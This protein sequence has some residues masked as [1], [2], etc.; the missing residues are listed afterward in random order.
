M[1]S[2]GPPGGSLADAPSDGWHLGRGWGATATATAA[3]GDSVQTMDLE[4]DFGACV[5]KRLSLELFLSCFLF[6][7]ALQENKSCLGKGEKIGSLEFLAFWG[8]ALENTNFCNRLSLLQF[9]VAK[10]RKLKGGDRG[11]EV[12]IMTEEER[13]RVPSSHRKILIPV[14]R[15]MDTQCTAISEVRDWILQSVQRGWYLFRSFHACSAGQQMKYSSL[16]GDRELSRVLLLF[17]YGGFC[18]HQE[19]TP[20]E[21]AEYKASS[22]VQ[23]EFRWA[24]QCILKLKVLCMSLCTHNR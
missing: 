1:S 7:F 6:S 16:N 9:L 22:R 19:P 4:G 10:R 24:R 8:A 17:S 21:Q 14:P 15:I 11:G 13:Q 18:Q 2:G 23:N 5:A 12:C 3:L 20:H